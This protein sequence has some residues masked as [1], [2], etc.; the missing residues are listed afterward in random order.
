MRLSPYFELII[1]LKHKNRH[2][3]TNSEKL[4][5]GDNKIT[6]PAYKMFPALFT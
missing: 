4:L 3:E 5:K 2:S 6:F 1:Q